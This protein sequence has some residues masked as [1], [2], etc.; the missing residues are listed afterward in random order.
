M[1]FISYNLQI[2]FAII[3]FCLITGC[4]DNKPEKFIAGFNEI[5]TT[6]DVLIYTNH[7]EVNN[8]NGHLQGIQSI[9]GNN[10][11]KYFIVSGSSDTCS[12]S[13]VVKMG[14]ENKVY[15][16]TNLMDKPF[17]HAGGF[18]I[19]KNY[20]AVGIED[21]TLKNKSEV[22]IYDVSNPEKPLE[23]PIAII[24]RKGEILRSTAGCV[25]IT[26]YKN[27]TLLAVGDWD[28]KN[29]DFYTADLKNAEPPEFKLIFTIDSD[30]ISREGWINNSWHS[31]QNINLFNIGDKLYLIGLGQNTKSENIADL[32][33][34]SE[35]SADNFSLK[36]VAC[37]IFD[38]TDECSFKAGAGVYYKN[39]ELEIYACGYNI[40]QASTI[41]VFNKNR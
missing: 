7:L 6:P 27:L 40:Q 26:N 39:G 33:E 31:Y 20:M 37:K 19:F 24:S 3:I 1:L 28:T 21:N 41:N 13:A 11:I 35:Y 10:G 9:K 18:Q 2:S 15:S 12:Y 38:C 30:N 32:F 29:I 34:L 14:D 8:S 5:R 36:K 17:V 25:G 16:I 23:E 22:H 4:S